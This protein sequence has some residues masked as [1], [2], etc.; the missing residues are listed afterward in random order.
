MLL[1]HD[2]HAEFCELYFLLDQGMGANY[3]LGVALSDVTASFAFAVV[4]HGASEQHNAVA[5]AFE[6][7]SSREI[8]LLGENFR[9]RHQRDLVSVFHGNNRGLKGDDGFTRAHIALQQAAHGV[10]FFH[11]GGDFFQHSFLRGSWDGKE[12]FS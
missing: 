3:Q 12:E 6:N 1:V 5:G 8:V 4:L 10:R 7:A 9:R 2:Y 11:V